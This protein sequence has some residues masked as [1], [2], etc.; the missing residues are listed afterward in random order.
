MPRII[1]PLRGGTGIVPLTAAFRTGRAVTGALALAG[2]ATGF[3]RA[4]AFDRHLGRQQAGVEGR[5]Q[6]Q[7]DQQVVKASLKI[8]RVAWLIRLGYQGVGQQ[9]RL[10]FAGRVGRGLPGFGGLIQ[11]AGVPALQLL[12][13]RDVL[14]RSGGIGAV[15]QTFE[16]I[17][18]GGGAGRL[19]WRKA[20]QDGQWR[21]FFSWSAQAV[22]LPTRAYVM[23]SQERNMAQGSL[24]APLLVGQYKAASASRTGSSEISRHVAS[25]EP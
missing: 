2:R 9:R 15:S 11:A 6:P 24:G 10:G 22:G 20:C 19:A 12:A 18:M 8:V 4:I 1:A 13:E 21:I 3:G 5:L 25:S 7:L 14:L 23:S 17:E 16:K